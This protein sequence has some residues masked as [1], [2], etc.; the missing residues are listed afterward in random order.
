MDSKFNV[1]AL[2][3]LALTILGCSEERDVMVP[4]EVLV[5]T[6]PSE[7]ICLMDRMTNEG[8]WGVE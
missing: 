1:A 8:F 4:V 2:F 3:G 5:A 7:I 6:D